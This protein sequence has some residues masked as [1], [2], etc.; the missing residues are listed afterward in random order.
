MYKL[1]YVWFS[2]LS[3]TAD[4]KKKNEYFISLKYMYIYVC[5]YLKIYM[6]SHL[7][8]IGSFLFFSGAYGFQVMAE[9]TLH[10]WVV[11]D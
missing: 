4:L 6:K 5:I 1:K 11:G 2:L 7:P 9:T 10:S 3:G 8:E